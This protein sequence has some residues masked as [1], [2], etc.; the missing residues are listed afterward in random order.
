MIEFDENVQKAI[1]SAKA[2][3][4]EGGSLDIGPLLTAAYLAQGDSAVP[5]EL[6]VYLPELKP[7]RQV[8]GKV[9]L[10]DGLKKA[11][12]P[13]DGLGRISPAL[14]VKVLLCCPESKA[15][16]RERGIPDELLEAESPEA[17]APDPT[18]TGNTV[19]PPSPPKLDPN[20]ERIQSFGRFLTRMDLPE[21]TRFDREEVLEQTLRV[22]SKMVARN[23][24]LVGP[25]GSGKSAAV[26]ELARRIRE[27]HSSIPAHLQGREV[28][29]LVPSLLQAGISSPGDLAQRCR[30]IVRALRSTR[31]L[32]YLDQLGGLFQGSLDRRYLARN[33][34]DV[35]REA[36]AENEIACIGCASQADYRHDIEPDTKL[37]RYFTTVSVKPP[38]PPETTAILRARVP[39]LEAF[40]RSVRIP[41]AILARVVELT[42][43]LLPSR[44]QPE[45]S[46]RLVDEA[47]AWCATHTPPLPIVTEE[48][49]VTALA[50]MSG[51][52]L[53]ETLAPL[54]EQGIVD[55]LREVILGQVA[56]LHE[57]SAAVVAGLG[58]WR[59]HRGPRGVF[60]FSGPTG[61]GKTE[62]ALQLARL[63]GHRS[64]ALLR[65]DCNTLQGRADEDANVVQWRLLGVAPGYVGY[66]RGEG[67]MLSRVR[68]LGGGVV[69]FDEIEKAS[70]S[71]GKLLLQ[72]IDEGKVEDN[73]GNQLDFR[74]V[75][76]VFTTNAGCSYGHT[77]KVGF[78]AGEEPR[79]RA[80]REDTL[81]QLADRFGQEFV[82]RL[83][84]TFEFGSLD[85]PTI[86]SI[87]AA[88]LGDLRDKA[89]E[90]GYDL[91]WDEVLPGWIASSWQPEFGV[92][93]LCTIL[94]HRVEEQLSV[95][96]ARGD[97][98]DVQAIRLRRLLNVPGVPA[99]A[100]RAAIKDGQLVIELA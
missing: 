13:L 82:A 16:L 53:R 17:S 5:P 59:A 55:R 73:Q 11:L 71:V 22:L 20:L 85:E 46:L 30:S 26:V 90:R 4:E 77:R 1:E 63:L 88:R 8:V 36:I 2:T 69:L 49:L 6:K 93:H 27:R 18:L 58:S 79:A 37:R 62:T 21:R 65:I 66:V 83:T 52:P 32:L 12:R 70:S 96:E 15:F 97:L 67:G 64:E 94:A 39:L 25:P 74:R 57:V 68:D 72:I 10:T 19:A 28:F 60:L 38:S 31:A 7:V 23:V 47:C 3:V 86:V 78:G 95:A 40:Y 54:T 33:D 41:E 34:L 29:E 9:P 51:L 98:R 81:A 48:A 89:R 44:H 42:D 56:L 75:F 99:G 50:S 14:L 76:L 80:S 84:H 35:L 100:G 61:V 45:K 43:E 92:R 91:S 87:V 24:V